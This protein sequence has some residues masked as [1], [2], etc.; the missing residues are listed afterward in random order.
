[1]AGGVRRVSVRAGVC[2][3]AG[4]T[5]RRLIEHSG[6]PEAEVQSR[7]EDSDP[8]V[9][10]RSKE[11]LQ[12]RRRN[13]SGTG[14]TWRETSQAE[15]C[16]VAGRQECCLHGKNGR[17]PRGGQDRLKEGRRHLSSEGGASDRYP[18]QR[19]PILT[20]LQSG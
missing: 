6:C 10:R 7:G 13:A 9:H 5:S 2:V 17:H 19:C 11:A 8:A 4:R 1:M 12:K 14:I 15:S 18:D 16:A 20:A 3:S